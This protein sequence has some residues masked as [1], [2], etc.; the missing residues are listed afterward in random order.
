MA[1]DRCGEELAESKAKVQRLRERLSTG[2]LAVLKDLSL[3]SH[4]PKWSGSD[5][6]VSL[7]EFSSFEGSAK[8][9][10]WECPDLFASGCPKINGWGETVL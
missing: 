2:I 1:E 4:F 10:R 9:C 6:A 5:R 8:I 7:E 3:V